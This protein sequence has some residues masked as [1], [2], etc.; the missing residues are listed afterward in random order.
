MSVLWNDDSKMK[1]IFT[2]YYILP[3]LNPQK[4]VIGEPHSLT[5]AL[6]KGKCGLDNPV[7]ILPSSPIPKVQ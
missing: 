6:I 1:V 4:E 7:P 2:T 3:T 5:V